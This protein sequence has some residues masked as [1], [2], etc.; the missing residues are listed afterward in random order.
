MAAIYLEV[1]DVNALGDATKLV[2]PVVGPELEDSVVQ[3]IFAQVGQVHDVTTWIARAST[4]KL[5][6][7][8]LAMFYVGW[9]YQKVYSE[10]DNPNS[11]GLLLIARG[12]RLVD[13]IIS[14]A[15]ELTDVTVP[16]KNDGTASFYPNDASSAQ[17]PTTDDRSLGKEHFSMG[18]IW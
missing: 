3:E 7:K 14:G 18:M 11:F 10:D 8:I 5:I 15:V 1:G 2:F 13:G 6:I 17:T 4:P 16:A 12:Q 9:H